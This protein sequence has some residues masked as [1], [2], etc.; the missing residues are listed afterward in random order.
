MHTAVLYAIAMVTV[1]PVLCFSWTVSDG[2]FFA[3]ARMKSTLKVKLSI[4][5]LEMLASLTADKQI[6]F[7]IDYEVVVTTLVVNAVNGSHA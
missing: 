2:S 4:S 7:L 5:S 1:Y 6:N 3:T